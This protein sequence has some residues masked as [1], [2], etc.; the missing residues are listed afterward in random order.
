MF[1]FGVVMLIMWAVKVMAED[2][3]ATVKG[4]SNPRMDRRRARQK[5][6]AGNPIWNQFVG[7]LGDVA[8]DAREE[9]TR[10]RQEKRERQAEERRKRE[11]AEHETVDAEYTI[12]PDPESGSTSPEPDP[13]DP[14]E[15]PTPRSHDQLTEDECT[16]DTCPV[17]GKGRKDPEPQADPS[18]TPN[19][20][21]D[22]SE[23]TGLDQSIAYANAV[24]KMAAKHGTAGN[25]GYIG[26]LT[27]R[28]VTGE[29]L[30]SAYDM[31]AAM[32]GAMAAAEHHEQELT[33]QKAVQEQYDNNAD[34]GDKQFQT[35][36]R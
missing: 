4:Q 27:E 1:E 12:D 20:G 24:K 36:G 34:A 28:N 30:Q 31:Q 21:D 10:A 33:K 18:T 13:A 9:Q 3:W 14:Q 16:Y 19:E 8:Q 2:G 6:R 7:W 23:I 29:A 32:S 15:T 26:H 5:S 25:E 22:M 17:H 35:E 11:L